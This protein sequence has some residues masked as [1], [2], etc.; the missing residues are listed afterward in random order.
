MP[1]GNDVSTSQ[2]EHKRASANGDGYAGD[3]VMARR[4]AVEEATID[5]V[6]E[7]QPQFFD[8]HLT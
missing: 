1:S 2:K 8:G 4:G 5:A 6:R 7:Y 3:P